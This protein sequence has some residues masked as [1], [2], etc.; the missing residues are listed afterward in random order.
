[1]INNLK[2]YPYSKVSEYIKTLS[3]EEIDDDIINTL[4]EDSRK[5]VAALG[6][7]LEKRR[8]KHYNEIAR[9]LDMYNFDRSFKDVAILAGVDEVGRGPLAGPIVAAAVIIKYDDLEANLIEGINDSKKLSEKKRMELD[10]IIKE[11]AIAYNIAVIS[12]KEIDEKGIAWCNNEVLRRAVVNLKIKPDFVISDGYIVKGLEI[13]N[14]YFHKGDSKSAAIACASI[15]AKVFRD[16][17]MKEYH[18][19]FK[20]YNLEKNVGYGSEEH[21]NAIKKYGITEI[22]RKSFLKNIL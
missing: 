2:E 11:K 13:N 3:I 21:I 5:N 14:E 22:H 20:E 6:E 18:K 1:M 12:N 16:S 7:R 8:E 17:L 4:K 9:V 15:I 19:T 10:S